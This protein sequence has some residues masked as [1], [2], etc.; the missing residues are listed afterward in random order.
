MNLLTDEELAGVVGHELAH[1]YGKDILIG[2]IVATIAG[3]MML[4]VDIFQWG[5]ILGGNNNDEEGSSHPL[6]MVA[7]IAIIILAPIAASLIQMAVSRSREYIAD[8]RGA[9]FCGNP[10]ALASAL[11]KIAYGV[12]MHHMDKASPQTA[13]MF[14]MNPLT[15][16][17]ISKLFSTHPPVE[18]RM[19]RLEELSKRQFSGLS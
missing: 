11:N 14:I 13:H 4:M 6:G 10:R 16:S 8:E 18:E 5:L 9:K 3:A 17:S 7:S 12:E 19:K 2:S 15:A 1:I